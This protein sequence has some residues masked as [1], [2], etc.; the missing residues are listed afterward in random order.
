MRKGTAINLKESIEE[1]IAKGDG[2]GWLTITS[3]G[4]EYRITGFT[5][6]EDNGRVYG[7]LYGIDGRMCYFDR[8]TVQRI[9]IS[10]ER[11]DWCVSLY[12][13]VLQRTPSPCL[14]FSFEG[15][16]SVVVS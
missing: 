11:D 4:R 10:E 16:S 1:T 9:P 8:V 7:G 2:S 13:N 5:D 12:M 3:E 15:C 6:D 14:M